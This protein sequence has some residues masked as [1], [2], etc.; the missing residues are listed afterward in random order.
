[1]TPHRENTSTHPLHWSWALRLLLA[2]LTGHPDSAGF[3]ADEIGDCARCWEIVALYTA[4]LAADGW[5]S[6]DDHDA[7]IDSLCNGI[8]H[9]LDRL[10]GYEG[11][12]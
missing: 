1:L 9:S 10:E 4:R 8:A 12:R 6:V 7:V 11:S 3:V 5:F 2:Y